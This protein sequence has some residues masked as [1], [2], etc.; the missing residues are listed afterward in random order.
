MAAEEHAYA[1][2]QTEGVSMRYLLSGSIGEGAAGAAAV[3]VSI[4]GLA[5]FNAGMLIPIAIIVIGGAL[6]FEGTARA[7]RFNRM[8]M[9]VSRGEFR[10]MEMGGGVTVELIGGLVTMALGVLALLQVSMMELAPIAAI[11]ASASILMGSATTARM[12]A[13]TIQR[14]KEPE[15]ARALAHVA[16]T[17]GTTLQAF[18]GLGGVVLG[19]LAISG[20]Y[21]GILTL[22]TTL[23]LGFALLIGGS[24]LTGMATMIRGEQR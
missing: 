5:A 23:S 3:V 21:P 19:I 9:E 2:A 11:V 17:S 8:L 14:S 10:E 12:N 4:A 20:V 13:I 6:T 22:V 7:A 24:A 1:H 16:M 15:E 18:V